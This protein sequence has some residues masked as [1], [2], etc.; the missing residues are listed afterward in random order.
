MRP[1]T[2]DEYGG[3]QPLLVPGRLLRRLIEEK[4]PRSLIFYGP[5]CTGKTTLAKI[6]AEAIGA[7]FVG[8][9]GVMSGVKDVREAVSDARL[10][11]M[12]DNK[13]TVLFVDEIHRFNKAQQDALLP[14]VEKGTIVLVDRKS[15]V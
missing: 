14:Y 5:A 7:T 15:V 12:A 10:R 6:Y 3:Q 8:I 9:S 11:S 1:R 13:A 4:R 2:L